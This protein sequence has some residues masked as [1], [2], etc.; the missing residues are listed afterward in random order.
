MHGKPAPFINLE[1]VMRMIPTMAVSITLCA[2]ALSLAACGNS[3]PLPAASGGSDSGVAASAYT[4]SSGAFAVVQ[5]LSSKDVTTVDSCNVDAVNDKPAGS[6]PLRHDSV[7]TFAG[8]GAGPQPDAVPAGLQLVLVGAQDYVVNAA[9]G[10]PRP[11]VAN[12]NSH[13]AWSTSGYSVK[14]DLS[15]VAPG[16]YTPVLRFSVGG[17]QVQCPTQHKLTIQ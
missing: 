3:T 8:W 15:A 1:P 2:L 12:A 16:D 14:A 4:P 11:D 17:K 13:P 9:T 6:E 10:M 7:A 5:N